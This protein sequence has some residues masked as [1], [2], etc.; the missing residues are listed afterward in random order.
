MMFTLT[1][2]DT[3]K[4]DWAGGEITGYGE[5]C[6]GQVNIKVYEKGNFLK[7][8]VHSNGN[9]LVI[10]QDMKISVFQRWGLFLD[11]KGNFWVLSSDVGISVWEK[12]TATGQY[13]KRMFFSKLSKDDVPPEL[14]E[15]SLRR[16]L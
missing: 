3:T 5:Y 10:Q 1:S 11:K 13:R 16:F 2:C 4:C 8:E 12:D 7:Y 14:Y 6:N 9:E 15:S